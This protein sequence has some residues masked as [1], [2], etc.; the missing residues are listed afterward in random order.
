MSSIEN[1]QN[2]TESKALARKPREPM[3]AEAK[4]AMAA[5]RAA[6]LAAKPVEEKKT[7]KPREP[8]SE[9]AKVA[10]A[11]KRV[12]TLAAKKAAFDIAVAIAAEMVGHGEVPEPAPKRKAGKKANPV[13]EKPVSVKDKPASEK[14]MSA[15]DKPMSA[16]DKPV[17]AK[18][19]PMSAKDK[20]VSVNDKP[21]SPKD[22]PMSAKDK[23]V[24]QEKKTRKP[25]T[26]EAKLAMAAKR[27]ATLAAKPQAEEFVVVGE[28]VKSGIRKRKN[29]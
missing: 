28:E 22:K 29:N 9:D 2:V 17:S 19:K 18:D 13:S 16:K 1:K 7:R 10:M 23:P 26:E 24:S 25:M 5:K 8:M 15:K 12:A 20:P 14:P 21:M 3:T 4:A 6:T 27:A 11:A